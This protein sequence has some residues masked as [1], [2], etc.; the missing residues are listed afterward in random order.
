M[1]DKMLQLARKCDVLHVHASREPEKLTGERLTNPGRVLRPLI[2]TAALLCCHVSAVTSKTFAALC[3]EPGCSLN[4]MHN[5]ICMVPSA[6]SDRD[7]S[8]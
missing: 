5:A 2:C 3:D 8:A 4:D 6:A 7:T 1:K